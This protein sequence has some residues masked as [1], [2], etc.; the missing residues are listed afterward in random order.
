M[1]LLGDG[2]AADE[3]LVGPA[4]IQGFE[5]RLLHEGRSG[6]LKDGLIKVL[7]PRHSIHSRGADFI[8]TCDVRARHILDLNPFDGILFPVLIA[9]DE[10]TVCRER[11]GVANVVDSVGGNLCLGGTLP[12][13]G[14]AYLVDSTSRARGIGR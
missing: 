12:G 10:A 11:S 13:N 5:C 3:L 8:T 1:F 9:L 7:E 14:H 4:G 6:V 2:L